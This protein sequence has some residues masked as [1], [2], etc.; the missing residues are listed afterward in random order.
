MSMII[1]TELCSW[2]KVQLLQVFHIYNKKLIKISFEKLRLSKKS[3]CMYA[4]QNCRKHSKGSH[5]STGN[6]CTNDV[7]SWDPNNH[8]IMYIY[9]CFWGNVPLY[10]ALFG[11]VRLLFSGISTLYKPYLGL[12]NYQKTFFCRNYHVI[13]CSW[14]LNPISQISIRVAI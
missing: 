12:Y 14:W 8:I 10:T 7:Y 9:F 2:N 11:P 3:H 1:W 6:W 13:C 5:W 4:F